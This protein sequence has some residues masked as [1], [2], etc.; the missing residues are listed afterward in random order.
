MLLPFVDYL[1]GMVQVDRFGTLMNNV[2]LVEGTARVAC[3]LTLLQLTARV[4]RLLRFHDT[5]INNEQEIR[6]DQAQR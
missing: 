4:G 2:E 3:M 1:F 6:A 5:I